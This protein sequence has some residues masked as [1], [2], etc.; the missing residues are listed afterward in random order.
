[1]RRV[2]LIAAAGLGAWAGPAPA[3]DGGQTITVRRE[4]PG[5]K[6]RVTKA[7]SG[8]TRFAATVAGREQ[9]REEKKGTKFVYTAEVRE[10]PAG[11]RRPVK[12]VRTYETAE[13]TTDGKTDKLAYDGKAVTIEKRGGKYAFT[14]EGDEAVPAA[15]ADELYKE[16]NQK[17]DDAVETEDFFPKRPVGLN[18][19]WAVDPD[20]VVR[21]MEAR[22]PFKFDRAKTKVTG[23]L[24]RAYAKGGAR[25]GTVE[26]ALTL[27]PTALKQPGR[28]VPLKPGST[29]TGKIEYDGC[30]DGTVTD[31][32]YTSVITLDLKADVPN[33]ALTVTGSTAGKLIQKQVK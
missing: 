33:G 30:I 31:T 3:Q 5:D 16:F 14:L 20:L 18:E 28:E 21:A 15:D 10:W 23:T 9:A 4:Q 24:T 11:A 12:L 6:V 26:L 32:T 2:I 22:A 29:I 19:T 7:D 1:M 25:Y 17:S 8:V 13:R 27:A